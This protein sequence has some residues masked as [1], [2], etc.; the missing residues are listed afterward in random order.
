ME[1]KEKIATAFCTLELNKNVNPD[2][3]VPIITKV[4]SSFPDT[5]R[6]DVIVSLIG[7][8]KKQSYRLFID[9]LH[10]GESCVKFHENPYGGEGEEFTVV[11]IRL[12]ENQVT[13]SFNAVFDQI[14]IPEPGIY[15]IK[16][17]LSNK[18]KQVIDEN[19]YYFD[20]LDKKD[21]KKW[22]RRNS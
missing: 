22:Q 1:I 10:N 21:Y 6:L 7:L 9:I 20:V 11:N 14:K 12:P 15:E 3:L 19:S 18:E 5:Q 8:S 2:L 4:V 17:K 16:V 13:A